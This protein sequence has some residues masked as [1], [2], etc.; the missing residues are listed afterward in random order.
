MML[1][2]IGIPSMV[3]FLKL[4]FMVFTSLMVMLR[5]IYQ[6]IPLAGEKR[7]ANQSPLFL[8]LQRLARIIIPMSPRLSNALWQLYLTRGY[9]QAVTVVSTETRISPDI[10]A[11]A[12]DKM[13][14]SRFA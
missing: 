12:L 14:D 6:F 10:V 5:S 13:I 8:T 11:A 4:P 2:G 7:K 3:A 1:A 9:W